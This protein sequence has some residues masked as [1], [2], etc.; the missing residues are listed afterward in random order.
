MFEKVKSGLE[1]GEVEVSET[2]QQVIGLAILLIVVVLAY[3]TGR[4]DGIEAAQ[5]DN[6]NLQQLTQKVENL[7]KI[8]E[9]GC[10]R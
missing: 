3:L 10:P 5:R 8:V 9:E 7:K 1:K 6:A 4:G 2:R